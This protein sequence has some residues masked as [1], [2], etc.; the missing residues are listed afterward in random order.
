MKSE[1]ASVIIEYSH[2][3]ELGCTTVQIDYVEQFVLNLNTCLPC[4][5]KLYVQYKHLVTVTQNFTRSAMRINCTKLK[6]I[7]HP[8]LS[9]NSKIFKFNGQLCERLL[10]TYNIYIQS[11]R[12]N[13]RDTQPPTISQR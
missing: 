7:S 1:Q 2:L 8:I 5:S 13:L 11:D 4:L 12:G 6:H 3:V 9:E 10:F